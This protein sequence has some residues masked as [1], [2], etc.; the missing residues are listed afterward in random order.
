[1]TENGATVSMFERI[2]Q[3]ARLSAETFAEVLRFIRS[4]EDVGFGFTSLRLAQI[5]DC[6][7]SL[8]VDT[9]VLISHLEAAR[10][11]A[12]ETQ[13]RAT[14]A[15]RLAA[16]PKTPAETLATISMPLSGW[17]A[18]LRD[19]EHREGSSTGRPVPGLLPAAMRTKLKFWNETCAP[20]EFPD[21][22]G[23]RGLH[24]PSINATQRHRWK[25]WGNIFSAMRAVLTN[26]LNSTPHADL[27][28]ACAQ[29]V[30][31]SLMRMTTRCTE[32]EELW[33]A[34]EILQRPLPDSELDKHAGVL[35]IQ[36]ELLLERVCKAPIVKAADDGQDDSLPV[37]VPDEVH[38]EVNLRINGLHI[39]RD[40][41]EEE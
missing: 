41:D 22:S 18:S 16:N 40:P 25:V 4:V 19:E 3:E 32:Q 27:T 15:A 26:L 37:L 11:K 20:L 35:D 10:L 24:F 14:K 28:F 7:D 2:A 34:I 5:A 30:E 23:R 29:R 17:H 36:I 31:L 8:V 1:M 21:A 38:T 39:T 6:A 13:A 12:L 9:R 33:V